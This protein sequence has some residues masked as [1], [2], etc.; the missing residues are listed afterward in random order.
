MKEY[1]YNEIELN[2]IYVCIYIHTKKYIVYV[3]INACTYKYIYI[4]SH[5]G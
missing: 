4:S 2:K 1:Y 3:Y 5:Y